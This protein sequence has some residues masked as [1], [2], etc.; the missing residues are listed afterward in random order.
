MAPVDDRTTRLATGGLLMAAAGLLVV[1]LS[2]GVEVRTPLPLAL[3]VAVIGVLYVVAD[4]SQF[5][6]EVRGQ[7]LS[8]S[9]SD[10]PLVLSLFLLDSAWLLVA[11]LVPALIVFV[12][13]RTSPPK[14]FFNL[15]LFTFEVALAMAMLNVLAPTRSLGPTT[16][17]YTYLAVVVVD[18]FG[19]VVVLAA[20]RVLGSQ[21]KTRA[22]AQSVG[23]VTLSGVLSTTLAL[24]AVVVLYASSWGLVM[25]AA[26]ALIVAVAH[27]AYYRLL[28]NYKD[29]NRLFTFTQTVGSAQDAEAVVA[30]LQ[31]Q[32]RELLS[33]ESAL[34]RRLPEKGSTAEES[35]DLVA[36]ARPVVL[37][38]S[39]RDPVLRRWLTQS[40]LRDA[41]LVPLRD[42]DEVVAML[43]VGNREGAAGSFTADDLRLL[44]TLVAHAQVLWQNGRLVEKL[45]YDAMHDSLTG[46]S[47]RALFNRE[48]ESLLEEALS[49]VVLLLDLD[50][51]KEV[52]DALGHPVGDKLLEKVASRLLAHVPPDAVV[53]R[54]GG[55]EFAVLLKG[56]RSPDEALATARAA[57]AALTGPFEVAGTFLEVGA[58]VGVAM[59]PGDGNDAATVLRRADLAMYEAK[60]SGAGVTHYAPVLDKSST[61]RLELAGELRAALETEQIVM[62][63]QPKASLRT[64]RIVGFEALAR[65]HHP[66]RG[67]V[68]PDVFIPLAEQT[69]LVGQLTHSALR[70]SLA[71]C[72]EW[73]A[74]TPGVGVAVNL[75]PRRLLEPGLA[76]T[77]RELLREAGVPADLLTLE[78]TESSVMAE[79]EASVRAL[80]QLR[81]LGVRL[82]IDDFGTG[83]SSLNYLQRLPVHEVKIDKSFILPMSRDKGAAAIV[84]TV[85]DLAHTLGLTVVAEGVEDEATRDVL[86][87][88]GC[89]VQQGYALNWPVAAA[90]VGPWLLAYRESVRQDR[91]GGRPRAV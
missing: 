12:L 82:S 88:V 80:N 45:R 3:T 75:S 60:R 38:R 74:R 62:H 49:G 84:K 87:E 10:L 35:D 24:M 6:V 13:R 48:L 11:R 78:I 2:P 64:G 47:N 86:V 8:V 18:L 20:M 1:A 51:F 66:D 4:L 32:A 22:I 27:R 34:L 73:L 23:A 15:G 44:Q 54:L 14:A 16:W 81:E 25:L 68:M 50:R 90:E 40:H 58:S 85:V 77:V 76:S 29:L 56:E 55:D 89:D 71:G 57:R 70:Q 53:A 91:R 9:I 72:R 33:A 52:N 21:P 69:G 37:P 5:H 36:A 7:A 28:R 83:Y 61:D 79:P 30:Q 17:L 39:T 41:L 26:L 63:F 42:K 43:Q 19:T 59:V 31:A 67:T 46:L 65:W